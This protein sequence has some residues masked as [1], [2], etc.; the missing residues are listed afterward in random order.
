MLKDI[1]TCAYTILP[2]CV[3]EMFPPELR[4]RIETYYVHKT[5]GELKHIEYGK[6]ELRPTRVELQMWWVNQ[7]KQKVGRELVNVLDPPTCYECL[8]IGDE[9][10]HC[11][12]DPTLAEGSD[13][14]SVLMFADSAFDVKKNRPFSWDGFYK[15][16]I[17]NMARQLE[18]LSDTPMKEGL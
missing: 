16:P 3:K 12:L 13:P 8:F 18:K 10:D 6:P 4:V 9:H 7:Y 1:L 14:L 5:V 17:Y 15:C 11:V 2:K